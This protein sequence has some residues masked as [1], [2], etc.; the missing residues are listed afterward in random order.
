MGAGALNGTCHP[1][2]Q[3]ILESYGNSWIGELTAQQGQRSSRCGLGAIISNSWMG[4][5][6]MQRCHSLRHG[7]VGVVC[8]S[9]IGAVKLTMGAKMVQRC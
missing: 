1:L 6:M 5:P 7:L 3:G 8:N 2:R 4:V 9:W